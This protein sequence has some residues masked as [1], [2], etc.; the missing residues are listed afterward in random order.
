MNF[1]H[2]TPSCLSP[3]LF[4]FLIKTLPAGALDTFMYYYS[5]IITIIN[6]IIMEFR[7]ACLCEHGWE[8]I[9]WNMASSPVDAP[10][11]ETPPSLPATINCP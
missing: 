2:F 11:R 5:F 4:P 3:N 6:I 10:L 1:G 9:Y 8:A 7:W